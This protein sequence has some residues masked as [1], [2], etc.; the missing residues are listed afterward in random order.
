MKYVLFRIVASWFIV[1][2]CSLD[3]AELNMEGQGFISK[4]N[5][6]NAQQCGQ[7][8]NKNKYQLNKLTYK[9]N[10]LTYEHCRAIE[11]FI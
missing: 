6:I 4:V 9:L 7:K 1:S 8:N 5:I 3:N 11:S 2:P 10:K